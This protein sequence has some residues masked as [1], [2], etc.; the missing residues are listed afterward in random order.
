MKRLALL[1]AVSFVMS[2]AMAQDNP[3]I[4][5]TKGVKVET[6]QETPENSEETERHRN[7]Q[8]LEKIGIQYEHDSN[9]YGSRRFKAHP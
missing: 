5:K 1:V 2:T 9:N 4:V 7:A 3:Y 6:V 8:P